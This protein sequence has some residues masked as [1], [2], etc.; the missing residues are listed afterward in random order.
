MTDTLRP[1]YSSVEAQR[2]FLTLPEDDQRTLELKHRIEANAMNVIHRAKEVRTNLPSGKSIFLEPIDS[3]EPLSQWIKKI[4]HEDGIHYIG[5]LVLP[6][7]AEIS[8]IWEKKQKD[9][10]NLMDGF[11]L[12]VGMP[13]SE[14]DI[15]KVA[16]SFHIDDLDKELYWESFHIRPYLSW[17]SLSLFFANLNDGPLGSSFTEVIT[18]LNSNGIFYYGQIRPFTRE[19]L[20]ALPGMTEEIMGE[21]DSVCQHGDTLT[22]TS[23]Q[24]S[25]DRIN[26]FASWAIFYRK[27]PQNLDAM[28]DFSVTVMLDNW[29]EEDIPD[30]A[31]KAYQS[32]QQES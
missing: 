15:Q 21:L 23:L 25:N 7:N 11:E 31:M 22:P 27:Y 5:Q 14:Q 16:E 10:N 18:I 17:P 1:W 24:I 13:I 3:L 30:Y 8:W 28:N 19:E 32:R 6:R 20:C 2:A 29:L 4:L 9:L 12:H 26:Q